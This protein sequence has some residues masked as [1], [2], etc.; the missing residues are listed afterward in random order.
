LLLN[1]ESLPDPGCLVVDYHMPGMNGLESPC[2][3]ALGT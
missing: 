1:E 3:L 2:Y